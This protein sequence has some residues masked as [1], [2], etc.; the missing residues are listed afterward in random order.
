MP[1]KT[2]EQ[3]AAMLSQYCPTLLKGGHH[4]RRIG[5]DELWQDGQ[6]IATFP[7]QNVALHVKHGSG[8]VLSSAISAQLAKGNELITTCQER[9][10]Y[11]EAFL[12]SNETNLGYRRL[13]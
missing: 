11:V 10:A 3:A 6:L 8:C 2:P 13:S 4:A 1:H 12:N 5:E 9:K 7:A